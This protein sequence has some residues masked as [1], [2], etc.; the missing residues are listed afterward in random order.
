MEHGQNSKFK[1]TNNKGKNTKIGPK[2]GILK[3]QKF[4]GKCFNCGKQGKKSVD[5]RL[6]KQNKPKEANVIADISKNVSE[7]DLTVV[8]SEVN[9]VGSNPKE[10]WINTGAACH[11]CLDK[12]M[13]ST[14]DPIE[15]VEKVFMGN[16]TTSEI[17]GQGK[18]V[19]KMTYGKEVTLKN[20]LY[21][22][23]I[24]KN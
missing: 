10:W 24:R 20:V 12:K 1:K 21:V 23:K 14:F 3:K 13:L 19:S 4:L 9:L 22:P 2:G 17:K 5:C 7:I 16:L 11:V 15:T 18:V 8:I 6:P